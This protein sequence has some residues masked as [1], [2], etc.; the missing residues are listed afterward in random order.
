M[1]GPSQASILGFLCSYDGFWLG[2]GGTHE[3]FCQLYQ[4]TE[5]KEFY[6]KLLAETC[7]A[8]LLKLLSQAFQNF[9]PCRKQ[10]EMKS[11]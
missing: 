7:Q 5:T 8:F 11:V 1:Q 6:V 3:I 9:C 4:F 10:S 2:C